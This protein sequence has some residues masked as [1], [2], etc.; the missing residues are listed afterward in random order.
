[1][2]AKFV[3]ENYP[4]GAEND[5]AAPWNQDDDYY[6]D[7]DSEEVDVNLTDEGVLM[8]MYNDSD[9]TV[10]I[11]SD[12]INKF[13]AGKLYLDAGELEKGENIE[14]KDIIEKDESLIFYTDKGVV[15]VDYNE[16]EELA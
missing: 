15:T 5:P 9:V 7:D 1:M 4:L 6:I 3:N 11:G 16:L 12:V 14:I 13:L 10:T 2:K 8:L